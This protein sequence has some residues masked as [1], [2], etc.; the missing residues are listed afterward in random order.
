MN[1][2]FFL[3]DRK[4]I[5]EV[6]KLKICVIEVYLLKCYFETTSYINDSIIDKQSSIN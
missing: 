5:Y 6:L 2:C 3:A 1:S 4:S